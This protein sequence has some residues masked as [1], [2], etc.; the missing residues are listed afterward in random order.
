MDMKC[1]NCGYLNKRHKL[2]TDSQEQYRDENT[3]NYN[4]SNS[5]RHSIIILIPVY[6]RTNSILY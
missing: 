4:K 2:M 6:N 3:S 5:N 1:P